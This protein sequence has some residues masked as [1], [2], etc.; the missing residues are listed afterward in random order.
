MRNYNEITQPANPAVLDTSE[1]EALLNQFQ[2]RYDKIK[3]ELSP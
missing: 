2:E 3:G 1:L